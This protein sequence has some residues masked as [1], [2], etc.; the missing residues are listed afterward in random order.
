MWFWVYGFWVWDLGFR[1]FGVG[2]GLR[3]YCLGVRVQGPAEALCGGWGPMVLS[4]CRFF[5][6]PIGF[7][8][9]SSDF[10]VFH[11]FYERFYGGFIEAGSTRAV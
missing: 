9:G 10:S 11:G 7:C 4:L 1:D 6:G 8:K 5:L 2:F 3:D